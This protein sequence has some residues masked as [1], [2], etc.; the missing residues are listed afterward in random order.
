M[1]DAL[2]AVMHDVTVDLIVWSILY[3]VVGP[4]RH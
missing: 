2:T 1:L 3:L 4:D